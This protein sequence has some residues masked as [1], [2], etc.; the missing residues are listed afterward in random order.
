ML[1]R[2]NVIKLLFVGLILLLPTSSSWCF[3][4]RSSQEKHVNASSI[5][6]EIVS[7]AIEV[8]ATNGWHTDLD[9]VAFA[10]FGMVEGC[11][12][13]WQ[14]MSLLLNSDISGL[15]LFLQEPLPSL[16]EMSSA[17]RLLREQHYTLAADVLEVV[18]PAP[19]G[20]RL[21]AW[22]RIPA[23]Q[24]PVVDRIMLERY[25]IDNPNRLLLVSTAESMLILPPQGEYDREALVDIALLLCEDTGRISVDRARHIAGRGQ[26]D[27]AALMLEHIGDAKPDDVET[28]QEVAQWLWRACGNHEKAVQR[29]QRAMATVAEPAAREVRLDYLGYLQ[30]SKNAKVALPTADDVDTLS[31]S[32]DPLMAADALLMEGKPAQAAA[33]YRAILRDNRRPVA[34][35]LAAW[36]GLLTSDPDAALN[37]GE[38][39]A[40]EV[41]ALPSADRA[42]HAVWMGKRLWDVTRTVVPA[43]GTPYRAAWQRKAVRIDGVSGWE[44]KTADLLEQVIN[45]DETACLKANALPDRQS[46]RLPAVVLN[47]LANRPERAQA[48]LKRQVS[49]QVSAPKGGWR[50]RD[51]QGASDAPRTLT[52]PRNG[53]D[54]TAVADA[55]LAIAD[56]TQDPD[57]VLPMATVAAD[58]LA[59]K[60]ATVDN[61]R[62]AK[63]LVQCYGQIVKATV[64]SFDAPEKGHGGRQ[65]GGAVRAR[66]LAH[67]ETRLRGALNNDNV[68]R[69][70]P[71]LLRDGLLD[72]VDTDDESVQTLLT[73]LAAT[74]IDRHLAVTGDSTEIDNELGTFE[75]RMRAP[76]GSTT[77]KKLQHLRARSAKGKPQAQ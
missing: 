20:A 74:A 24:R 23:D 15:S 10:K 41:T 35:R 3:A 1:D 52:G 36:D 73:D 54:E 48:M 17:I 21:L 42:R 55:V 61:D 46:L 33:R 53:E 64:R 37:E 14:S 56:Y 28:Q 57:R 18:S 45:I 50:D 59:D 32:K 47:G 16:S 51:A 76:R 13:Y 58:H 6:T 5:F 40:Q 22:A 27:T 71:L 29:Y 38:A 8:Q 11:E 67:L 26:R 63:R 34:Q 49:W 43:R 39:L 7:S 31:R 30:W 60:M 75:Q 69:H 72:A 44:A 66:R 25:P 4:Q 65:Q 62:D 19:P 70:V 9:E 2:Y 77:R 12:G 68:A